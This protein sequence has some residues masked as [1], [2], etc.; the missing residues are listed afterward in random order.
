MANTPLPIVPFDGATSVPVVPSTPVTGTIGRLPTVPNPTTIDLKQVLVELEYQ[1]KSY[2]TDLASWFAVAFRGSPGDRGL[3]YVEY[4]KQTHPDIQTDEDVRAYLRG[5]QG[6]GLLELYQ[7]H[8]P[9]VKTEDELLERLTPKSLLTIVQAQHPD[10]QTVE[11]LIEYYRPKTLLEIYQAQDPSVKTEA[12]LIEALR[13]ES[14]LEAFKA[15]YPDEVTDVESMREFLRGPS[16]VEVTKALQ[17]EAFPTV[18]ESEQAESDLRTYLSMIRGEGLF[19]YLRRNY[20]NIYGPDDVASLLRGPE[21]PVGPSGLQFRFIG[22]YDRPEDLPETAEDQDGAFIGLNLHMYRAGKW[23]DLG[24][25]RGLPGPRGPQGKPGVKGMDGYRGLPG[26]DGTRIHLVEGEPQDDVGNLDDLAL[27]V[28]TQD[29]Y[30]KHFEGRWV[31]RGKLGGG[32]V[33][34]TDTPTPKVRTPNGWV[35]FPYQPVAYGV[36]V[37]TGDGFTEYDPTTQAVYTVTEDVLDVDAV[38]AKRDPRTIPYET[39]AITCDRYV[40]VVLPKVVGDHTRTLKLLIDYQQGIL[41]LPDDVQWGA[42]APVLDQPYH[43]LTLQWFPHAQ[44]WVVVS[45]S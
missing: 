35:A 34:D 8:Y 26:K 40:K 15:A 25:L 3:S 44:T 7:T 1:G 27:N 5:P 45:K 31:L 21:G 2:Q 11:D 33:Y 19:E 16:I 43:Q 12:D 24:P 9:D 36:Y 39:F 18:V 4:L 14:A 13:G 42:Y 6:R 10:V 22:Q 20:P 29:V 37:Y 17:P 38:N 41:A 28:H 23:Y 30:R 32:N